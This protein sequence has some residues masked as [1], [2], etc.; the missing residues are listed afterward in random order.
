MALQFKEGA[1]FPDHTLVDHAGAPV[2]ISETAAGAPLLLAFY[3]GP[4]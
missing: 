1:R 2:S 3:R 4:W